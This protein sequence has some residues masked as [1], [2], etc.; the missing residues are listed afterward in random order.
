[1]V[2]RGESMTEGSCALVQKVSLGKVGPPANMSSG[3]NQ[4]SKV[5]ESFSAS[6]GQL[7][8][9]VLSMLKSEVKR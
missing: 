3:G 1:M 8:N 7:R 2:S 9:S 4:N 6:Q 5:D